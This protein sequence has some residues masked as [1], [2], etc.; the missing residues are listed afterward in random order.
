MDYEVSTYY[1]TKDGALCQLSSARI[2]SQKL[3]CLELIQDLVRVFIQ[4]DSVDEVSVRK[5]KD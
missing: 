2:S 3:Y 5:V 1:T 4:M